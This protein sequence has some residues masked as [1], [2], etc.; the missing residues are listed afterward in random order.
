MDEGTSGMPLDRA[1]SVVLDRIVRDQGRSVLRLSELVGVSQSG[2]RRYLGRE[3]WHS[4]PI[5]VL[6]ALCRELRVP[7][8]DVIE[9]AQKLQH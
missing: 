1:I 2:L 9:E 7:L 6:D 5:G 3:Y 8:I 4:V